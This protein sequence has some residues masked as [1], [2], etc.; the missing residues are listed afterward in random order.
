MGSEFY[1]AGIFKLG[2]LSSIRF[3]KNEENR[4]SLKFYNFP[5]TVGIYCIW[6]IYNSIVIV[7][8]SNATYYNY[9]EP[10]LCDYILYTECVSVYL[11]SC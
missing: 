5:S 1:G 8:D 3:R 4:L 9:I 2:N 10:W 6:Y 11:Y 7:V